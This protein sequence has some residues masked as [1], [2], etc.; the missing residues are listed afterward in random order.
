MN[1]NQLAQTKIR[2]LGYDFKNY[3]LESFIKHVEAYTG[4]KIRLFY[5][6]MPSGKT[7]AWITYN[8]EG[9]DF[10]FIANNRSIFIQQQSVFH[11]VGHLLLGH[12]TLNITKNE[13]A[14]LTRNFQLIRYRSMYS[15]PEDREAEAF[16]L[17]VQKELLHHARYSDLSGIENFADTVG[18]I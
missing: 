2:S 12:K 8:E 5:K 6:S 14:L 17:F 15:A 1:L 9:W 4:R 18:M 13:F 3:T 16:A 10:I 7:G 11:E